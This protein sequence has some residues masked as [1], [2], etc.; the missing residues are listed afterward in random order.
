MKRNKIVIIGGLGYIGVELCKLYSGE[1]W[2][3]D[4]TVVDNKFASE[5]VKQLRDWGMKFVQADILD[6]DVMSPVLKDADVV[7][8]FAGITDVAYTKTEEN[9][10]KDK[11]ITEVG[12][13]GTRNVI[14]LTKEDCKIVFPSTHVV[15][16]GFSETKLDIKEDEEPTPILTYSR[17]KVQ[18]EK[19]LAESDKNYVVL[20]LATVCGYSS[21]TMRMNI[22]PNLFSR[23]ASQ[24]GSIKLFSG[25]VQLKSLVPLVDVARCAKFVAE[26]NDIRREIFHCSNESMTVKDVALI[27]K[28]INPALDIT[29]TDDE[30]PNLGYTI[31]NE[32]ILSTGFEFLY[33]IKDCIKEM[34]ENWSEKTLRPELEYTVQGG[35]EYVDDRGIIKNYELT[36]PINLIGW[37]ESTAGSIRANHY[38]PMQEQK[39]LLIAGQYISVIQDLSVPNAPISTKIINPG[40]IAII[41]PN[42]AH[43]MVFTDDS[44][45]LNLVRGERDHENYGI[46]HTIPHQ[47][48]S[49]EF[50]DRLIESYV[51]EC[52]SCGNT[53]L[54]RVVSLGNS[55]L[56]NNLLDPDLKRVEGTAFWRVEEPDTYPLEVDYC[57][58]CHNCQLS[59][60]V[61]PRKM[62]DNYLY[63]S[64]TSKKFRK[65]FEEAASYYVE[66]YKLDEDCTVVDIGSND[67]IALKPL[68]KHG[69]NVVGVEPAANVAAIAN[70]NGVETINA[71]FDGATV[72]HIGVGRA[73]L[74]TASNVFAHSD[75]L[76]D[77]T[78]NAFRLLQPRGTFIVEVQYLLDTM[79]DLTFD[80]I[81]HEHVNY[82]S[83][84]SIKNFFDSL[85]LHVTRVEHIDTHGGSIRVYINRE[86]LASSHPDSAT[87]AEFLRTE[88]EVGLLEPKSYR[89][90][91][92]SVEQIK[93]NARNNMKALKNIYKRIAAYGS[94]AKAT[95]S[96]NYFGI[97]NNDIEYTIEDNDLK[98]DKLIPGVNIPIKSKEYC[99]EN[100]PDLIIVLAWN[101]F[102]VIVENNQE[103]VDKGVKFI[104]IKE[105]Q[106]P[107]MLI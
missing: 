95:T 68:M 65:H 46:T 60:V 106:K 63:V 72:N 59:M 1:A 64:S 107:E 37:I 82:W 57:P 50:A 2:R 84:T 29:E 99:N 24:S 19:D 62:F 14:K 38:H 7:F 66:R 90:F 41:K 76:K 78:R 21:D 67:G 53:K 105:L 83:V 47:L 81:Y 96:L 55:P 56:A 79:A 43:T 85:G 30:I 58:D 40:D 35:D 27:C 102:D 5:R 48:V 20:R 6:Q 22:M 31:S 74:V 61:P 12:V 10:E 49:R 54:E 98:H 16:E 97:D 13:E 18:S 34:V 9:A 42:V 87:V 52:R 26:S 93:V 69:V 44:I 88:A 89:S 39:C 71:Y 92:R 15:Y 28:E 103:L 75:R 11:R 36:E 80:N 8:H 101:F 25:G 86:K 51:S 91:G 33:N 70:E 77:I 73:D 45:F 17:G 3:K 32:K 100:L 23:I 104:N 94:P 4:I